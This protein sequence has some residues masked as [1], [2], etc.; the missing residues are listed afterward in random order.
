MTVTMF[1]FMFTIGSAASSLLTQ[2]I[3]K[4]V[5]L[6]CNIIALINAVLVGIFGTIA[7]YILMDVP[8]TLKNNVCIGLMTVCIWIG[9]MIG[10]DKVTQTITQLRR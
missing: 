1:L 9:S 3:K 2:A 10:Y 4:A 5:A 8:F 6:E 7:A